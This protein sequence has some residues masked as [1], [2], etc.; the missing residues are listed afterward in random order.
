MPLLCGHLLLVV[1]MGV[2]SVTTCKTPYRSFLT[3]FSKGA[4]HREN[5]ICCKD[6]SLFSTR[7][8][9][10][11]WLELLLVQHKVLYQNSLPVRR[12][13]GKQLYIYSTVNYLLFPSFFIFI[14]LQIVGVALFIIVAL[15]VRLSVTMPTVSNNALSYGAFLGIYANLR[16]Q[17]LC[18][19]DKTVMNHFDVLGVALCLSTVMRYS[20]LLF[21]LSLLISLLLD[22]SW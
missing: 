1:H 14:F 7:L 21:S 16:Y 10:C 17:L 15:C 9:S 4:I 3:M 12:R 19:L 13:G 20:L 18:G 6:F 2:H 5:L 11:V 8:R 22:N